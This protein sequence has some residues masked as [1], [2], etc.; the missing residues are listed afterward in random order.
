MRSFILLLILSISSLPL[1]PAAFEGRLVGISAAS[2]EAVASAKRI[3]QKGGNVVDAAVSLTLVMGVT[4]PYFSALGGGGFAL[5][6]MNGKMEAI[7]FREVAPKELNENSFKDKDRMAS[8]TGGLAVGVPGIPKGLWEIHKKYG[9]LKWAVLVDDAI[10]VAE[11]G[12]QIHGDFHKRLNDNWD[13]LTPKGQKTFGIK[14]KAM[15]PGLIV[16]QKDL[17]TALKFIRRK[18]VDEFYQG[19]I[20]KD[21]VSSVKKAGGVI[22]LEDL[23]NYKVEWRTPTTTEYEGYKISLM[24]LPSSGAVVIPTALHLMEQWKLKNYS[25]YSVQELHLLGEIMSR[26]FRSRMMLADPKFFKNP[27]EE[28]LGNKY[29]TRLTRSISAYSAKEIPPLKEAD[30]MPKESEET[31]HLS[32][33]DKEGN[34]V[35]MTVT[36]NGEFGS[37][38]FTDKYGINLNNEI[39]DFTTKPGQENIFGLIQGSMNKVEPGK[40]PLSS[41]T[42][43]IVEKDGETRLVIG[44]PGGPK[45]ISAILQVMYRYLVNDYELDN[46]VQAP[47]FH[48]QFL[49][50]KLF[51]EKDKVFP[52]VLTD[53]RKKGHKLDTSRPAR[54]YAVAKEKD[55]IKAA[56]DHRIP[57]AAD[58][59]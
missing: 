29:L 1:Y 28:L 33:M 17:A 36:L 31:T 2:P 22:N 30:Y 48:H 39:D 10:K 16:K 42:P 18:G 3:M 4:N 57:G 50:N 55:S 51:Y 46:A 47:R 14:G 5:V 56:F 45:I 54:V 52:S 49:P 20:A 9:K 38:I 25:A 35:S 8:V 11:E 19:K 15:D 26:S 27:T 24:P 44:S 43:T 41:M 34:A 53:L 13:R 23:K 21:I 6:K 37:G 12:F 32:I 58:G 59:Y 40:R 7:D